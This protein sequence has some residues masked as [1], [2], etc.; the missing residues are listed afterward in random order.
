MLLLDPD[1]R[2]PRGVG[3]SLAL[4]LALPMAALGEVARGIDGSVTIHGFLALG[5]ALISLAT[6]DFRAPRWANWLGAGSIG[7]LAV[8]FAL[9]GISDLTH[10]P[11]LALLAYQV[12]GQRLEGVLIDLFLVWCIAVLLT[13]ARLARTPGFAAVAAA[14]GVKACSYVLEFQG[15]SLDARAPLLKLLLLAPFVWLLFESRKPR[16][17]QPA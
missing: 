11:S 3:G 4:L 13:D 9:Q 16:A 8:V 10:Q 1:S 14:A 5:S 6:F 17:S 2:S 12:L 7:T 15:A